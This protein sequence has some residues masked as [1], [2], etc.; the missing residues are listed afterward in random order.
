MMLQIL[1]AP[2][3][4]PQQ[5][6]PKTLSAWTR[7]GLEKKKGCLVGTPEQGNGEL[8][9]EVIERREVS[10]GPVALRAVRSW[11]R[12]LRAPAP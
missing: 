6:L 12:A 10:A 11:R 3:S 1:R 8:E 4:V 5:F 7:C 2:P 9:E